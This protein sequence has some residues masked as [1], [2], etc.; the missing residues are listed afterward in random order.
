MDSII[1][2][3]LGVVLPAILYGIFEF[4]KSIINDK[5][6]P[7]R[8]ESLIS[9]F[10]RSIFLKDNYI[11]DSKIKFG[12][13]GYDY[14]DH[15]SRYADDL[16]IVECNDEQLVYNVKEEFKKN[17]ETIPKLR[18]IKDFLLLNGYEE[19]YVYA[20]VDKEIEEIIKTTSNIEEWI[21]EDIVISRE[22]TSDRKEASTIRMSLMKSDSIT[23][24]LIDKLYDI[25]KNEEAFRLSLKGSINNVHNRDISLQDLS[26]FITS[27][28]VKGFILD[29]NKTY[30]KGEDLIFSY[31]HRVSGVVIADKDSYTGADLG[32]RAL[33]KTDVIIYDCRAFTDIALSYTEG[34]HLDLLQTVIV[35]KCM[36]NN[37]Y[38][39]EEMLKSELTNHEEYAYLYLWSIIKKIENKCL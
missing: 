18:K 32:K 27:V 15:D 10:G 9:K 23:R 13:D 1:S 37:Q 8:F 12:I 35:E 25:F 21:L 11:P 31:I 36:G 26:C 28:Y 14:I 38:S 3:I 17:C 2:I 16:I 20:V 39:V 22:D 4:I 5:L 33:E 24:R 30:L 7:E 29:R 19:C 34:V 6:S